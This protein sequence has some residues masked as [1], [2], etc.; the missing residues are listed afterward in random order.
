MTGE[1]A[2]A[3]FAG[4]QDQIRARCGAGSDRSTEANLILATTRVWQNQPR[5]ILKQ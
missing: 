3:R 1:L 2:Q 5:A 4:N